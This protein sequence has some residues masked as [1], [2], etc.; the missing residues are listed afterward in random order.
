VINWGILSLKEEKNILTKLHM[1]FSNL[2]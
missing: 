1:F 2:N